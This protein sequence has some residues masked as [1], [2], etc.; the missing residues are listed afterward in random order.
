MEC[1]LNFPSLSLSPFLFY[2]HPVS[3]QSLIFCRCVCDVQCNAPTVC[4]CT[5]FAFEMTCDVMH[6]RF[7]HCVAYIFKIT[8]HA[9]QFHL[10][11]SDPNAFVSVAFFIFFYFNFTVTTGWCVPCPMFSLPFLSPVQHNRI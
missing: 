10:V 8:R 9:Y 11:Q 2:S 4:R 1:N 3:C 6:M 7:R 5:C